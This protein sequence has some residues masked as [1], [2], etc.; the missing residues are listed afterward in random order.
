MV[1]MIAVSVMADAQKIT[2]YKARDAQWIEDKKVSDAQWIENGKARDAHWTME[3]I[4]DDVF[5]RMEGKS[6][7]KGCTVKREE[8]RYLRLMH[9]DKDGRTQMG[10]MVCNKA[11]AKDVVEIFKAL[12]EA[13]YRIERMRLI[14]DYDAD[15]ERSMAANN[16]SCFNFRMMTG[17]RTRVSKHGLG[18][19]IDINPLY[20]P[21]VKGKTVSPKGG[22]AYAWNRDKISTAKASAAN[23]DKISTAKA[24]AA[25]RDKGSNA[26]PDK[27]KVEMVIRK[28]DA[29]YREFVKRGFRWGGAWTRLKDYQHFEK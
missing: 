21:Y 20:N 15:D 3:R 9:W 26:T 25:N 10:E 11:I 18:M 16:T 17:S 29:C 28:G 23:R 14:D 5:R 24:S 1:M 7:G 13:G 22:R 12:Y 27:S 19:A 2:G 4:P 8:L 6:F